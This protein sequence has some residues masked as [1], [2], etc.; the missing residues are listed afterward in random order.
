M[1]GTM[2][3][4]EATITIDDKVYLEKN[5]PDNV[6]QLIRVYRKWTEDLTALKLDVALH[7]AALRDLSR[8]ISAGVAPQA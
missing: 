6:K 5:L 1:Q 2:E 3:A 8:E 4:V 7:E